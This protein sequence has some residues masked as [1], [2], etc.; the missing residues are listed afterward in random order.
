MT[1][2]LITAKGTFTV[3]LT[4][5]PAGT[6][7]VSY[8]GKPIMAIRPTREAEIWPAREATVPGI[9]RV[10][11]DTVPP[12]T[13]SHITGNDL[14]GKTSQQRKA[15]I[16]L[17]FRTGQKFQDGI[18]AFD[19]VD[20]YMFENW[21]KHLPS[22]ATETQLSQLEQDMLKLTESGRADLFK[23]N[24]KVNQSVVAEILQ[25][26]NGGSRNYKR[27]Q[28]A[29]T[30]LEYQNSTTSTALQALGYSGKSSNA[31]R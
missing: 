17:R 24:G 5:T 27:I 21:E 19:D 28:E 30:R 16:Y 2:Q 26:P 4:E 13:F 6:V 20:G 7:V 22:L 11:E 8:N 14:N 25:V 23:K 31:R 29:A 10:A 9:I 18:G 12:E 15:L 3:T 1:H